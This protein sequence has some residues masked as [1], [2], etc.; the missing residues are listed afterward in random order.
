MIQDAID[1][2]SNGD[3]IFVFDDSSPYYEN[4][5]IDRSIS[6]LG[7]NRTTTI[8]D[9]SFFDDVVTVSADLVTIAGFTIQNAGGA[10]YVV[11]VSVYGDWCTI[12]DCYVVNNDFGIWLFESDN[13][14]ISHVTV[15]SYR[16]SIS[17][18]DW[19]EE[20]VANYVTISDNVIVNS[21]S[22]VQVGDFCLE[23]LIVNNYIANCFSGVYVFC[24]NATVSGNLFEN[25][26]E[27]IHLSSSQGTKILNNTMDSNQRRSIEM[28]Y[29]RDCIISNNSFSECGIMIHGAGVEYFTHTISSD[30]QVNGKPLYYFFNEDIDIDGWEIGQLILVQCSGTVS[31]VNISHSSYA[32]QLAHCSN[33]TIRESVLQ[34]NGY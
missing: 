30:N 13:S 4:V 22:G 16:N 18:G 26:S 23:P 7:E 34:D 9:G 27:P 17:L 25:N 10:D 32:I 3:T 28:H 6:L 12:M 33:V 29:C 24:D 11:G 1:S 8:L 19:N 15:S 20:T 21:H 2:A 14:S 5:Q 31:K